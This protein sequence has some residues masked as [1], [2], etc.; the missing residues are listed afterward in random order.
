MR[1]GNNEWTRRS[2]LAAA[3]IMFMMIGTMTATAQNFRPVEDFGWG[4]GVGKTAPAVVDFDGDGLLDLYVGIGNSMLMHYE[5]R[6]GDKVFVRTQLTAANMSGDSEIA[7]F[8]ADLDGD[9]LKDILVGINGG[10]IRHYEQT[11]AG[12]DSIVL[13]AKKFNDIPYS[14]CCTKPF[15]IDLDGNGLLDLIVGNGARALLRWEQQAPGS[16]VFNSKRALVFPATRNGTL[17]PS[18]YDLDGDGALEMLLGDGSGALYLFR[19]STSVKDSFT[20]IATDWNGINANGRVAHWLGDLDEDGLV[21]LLYGTWDGLIFHYEQPSAKALDGWALR[22]ENFLNMWD[23]GSDCMG[24]VADLDKDG[25]YEVLRTQVWNQTRQTR[26]PVLMYR[27]QTEGS[28]RME[29]VGPLQGIVAAEHDMLWVGD[30]EDDGRLDML[31]TRARNGIE[32]YR[33][34]TSDPFLFELVS[35]AFITDAIGN[36]TSLVPQLVDLDKNGKKDL[37][38]GN[39]DRFISRYEQVGAGSASFEKKADRWMTQLSFYPAPAFVDLGNDGRLDMLVGQFDGNL[40][41]HVQS[42]SDPLLFNRV[43][44]SFLSTAVG[45][46]SVPH[47]VDFNKDGRL[48]LV[49]SDGDGGMSLYLDMGPNSVDPPEFLPS[50]LALLDIAPHPVRDMATLR[51]HSAT[52]RDATLRV[53]DVLGREASAPM[54]RTLDGGTQLLPLSMQGLRAG[55]YLLT[56]ESAGLRVARRVVVD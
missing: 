37:L 45:V 30:F 9:G 29:T 5:Q 31:I 22:S 8:I 16:L 42:A 26:A 21:D 54:S 1:G 14:D 3:M 17:H 15:V 32:H 49:I 34:S 6:A 25:R 7:P 4:F 24:T 35:D 19:Q 43:T 20:L 38:L 50:D 44:R 48:D 27:Q 51:V 52:R 47:V 46:K 55:V 10:E 28:P 33:Q 40:D 18:L 53:F 56:L 11:A 2:A 23:L 13:V 39:S 12:S 41:H 36:W